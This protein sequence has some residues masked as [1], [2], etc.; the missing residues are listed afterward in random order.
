[1][2][3]EPTDNYFKISHAVIE[4]PEFKKLNYS[5]KALYQVMCHLSNRFGNNNGVFYRSNKLLADDAGMSIRN[6][7]H[8]K[9]E[10]IDNGFLRW[11][12]GN[13]KE[14]CLYHVVV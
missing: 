4:S 12:Q 5:A 2:L 13:E 3:K 8:A 9:M 1:M 7:H 10:L 11:K 6:I 14:A